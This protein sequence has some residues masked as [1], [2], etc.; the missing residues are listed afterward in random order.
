MEGIDM[1]DLLNKAKEMQK[2]LSKRK[3]EA[4]T[5]TVEVTVGGGMVTIVMNGNLETP[6]IKID[7]EIVDKN[8]INTLEDLV[9][10]AANEA[11]RQAKQL[12]SDGLS[13]LM[14]DLKL[15]DLGDLMK[16]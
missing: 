16:K 14:G 7:P 9:R 6:S 5:K 8:D 12:V 2:N 13:D 3:E 15:P 11:V 1:K 4:A 10:S